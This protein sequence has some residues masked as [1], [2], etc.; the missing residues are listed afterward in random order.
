MCDLCAGWRYPAVVHALNGAP[1][2]TG[3]HMRTQPQLS[4]EF[5]EGWDLVTRLDEVKA[6]HVSSSYGS[7]D[8]DGLAAYAHHSVMMAGELAA[9][10]AMAAEEL[11]RMKPADIEAEFERWFQAP[12]ETAKAW[13]QVI[14]QF[15][16]DLLQVSVPV[17]G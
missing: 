8:G 2:M 13:E 1:I 10:A 6:G 5:R 9:L 15:H 3:G 14:E 11:R 17:R 12:L 4:Q 7:F 16:P